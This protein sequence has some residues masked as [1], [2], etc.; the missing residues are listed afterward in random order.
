MEFVIIK[1]FKVKIR[2]TIG[3]IKSAT[4]EAIPK[5]GVKKKKKSENMNRM[6]AGDPNCDNWKSKTTKENRRMSQRSDL[7]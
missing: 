2:A 7:F 6:E 4:L 5:V 3:E 1:I